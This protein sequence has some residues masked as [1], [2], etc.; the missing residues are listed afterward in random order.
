M[1]SANFCHTESGHTGKGGGESLH[2]AP[3]GEL[4]PDHAKKP[5]R[6]TGFRE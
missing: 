1:L 2:G 5:V 4:E 3:R 6:L